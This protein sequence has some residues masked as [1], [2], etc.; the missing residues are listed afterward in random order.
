MYTQATLHMYVQL[1]I[2]WINMNEQLALYLYMYLLASGSNHL[3]LHGTL[4]LTIVSSKYGWFWDKISTSWKIIFAGTITN[5]ANWQICSHCLLT[6]L[7]VAVYMQY[8]FH[9]LLIQCSI[10]EVKIHNTRLCHCGKS[11]KYRPTRDHKRKD[12]LKMYPWSI[13]ELWKKK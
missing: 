1:Y 12:A 4:T 8:F 11:S 13:K 7:S 10:N 2:P 3:H 5:D 6:L 9:F